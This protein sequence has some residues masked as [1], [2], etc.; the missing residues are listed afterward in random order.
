MFVFIP[1]GSTRSYPSIEWSAFDWAVPVAHIRALESGG[2]GT[3]QGKVITLD[4]I[5]VELTESNFGLTQLGSWYFADVLT[6]CQ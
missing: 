6:K 5:G 1:A 4:F 2:S 3:E